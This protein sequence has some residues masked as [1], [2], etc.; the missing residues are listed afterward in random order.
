MTPVPP[1][2]H[3]AQCLPGPMSCGRAEARAWLAPGLERTPLLSVTGPLPGRGAVLMA[4]HPWAGLGGSHPQF[5]MELK[6]VF[7]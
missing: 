1:E 4:P 3:R 5:L 6:D 2:S 7:L